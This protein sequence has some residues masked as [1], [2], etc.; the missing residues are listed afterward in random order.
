MQEYGSTEEYL[1]ALRGDPSLALTSLQMAA[2]VL[3]ITRAAVEQ[4]V[5]AGTL[6]GIGVGKTRW[7]S[8]SSVM[9]HLDADKA[10]IYRIRRYLERLASAGEAVSY[11]VLMEEFGMKSS[12]PADRKKIGRLLGKVSHETWEERGVLLSVLVVR[13]GSDN[14][15]PGFFNLANAIDDDYEDAKSDGDYVMSKVNDVYASYGYL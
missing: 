10:E 8:A 6:A 7:V 13:K 1:E 4:R 3:D 9:Q 15:G 2:D 11:S 5:R 12:I 14:P